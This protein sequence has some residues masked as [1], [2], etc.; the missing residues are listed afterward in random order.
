[1]TYA[2]SL[3]FAA[4]SGTVKLNQNSQGQP[5]VLGG[6]GYSEGLGVLAN[7]SISLALDGQDARFE[8]TIGVD[9]TAR[10]RARR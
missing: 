8:S 3:P 4:S 6:A 1:M 2:S 10:T 7:S 9:G 5:I